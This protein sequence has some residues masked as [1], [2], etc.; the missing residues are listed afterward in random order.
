MTDKRTIGDEIGSLLGEGLGGVRKAVEGISEAAGAL[1]RGVTKGKAVVAHLQRPDTAD[2]VVKRT[3]LAL[4]RHVL[5]EAERAEDPA[6]A[7][8]PVQP[9]KGTER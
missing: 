1:D 7:D 6:P 8:P 3:G 4:L 2:R 9:P 5:A